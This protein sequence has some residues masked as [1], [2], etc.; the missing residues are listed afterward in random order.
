MS[1]LTLPCRSDKASHIFPQIF[2]YFLKNST[3]MLLLDSINSNAMRNH[4][5]ATGNAVS[6][7]QTTPSK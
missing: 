3:K 1:T 6:D 5:Y 4:L 2:I 7:Q